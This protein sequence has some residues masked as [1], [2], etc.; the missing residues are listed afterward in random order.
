MTD[1][2]FIKGLNLLVAL[3]ESAE[4]RSLTRLAEQLGLTKSNTHRL[5]STLIDQGF[6]AQDGEKGLY[7]PTLRMWELGAAI[8]GRVD[9]LSVSREVL[10]RL[11]GETG[12][13][14]HLSTLAGHEVVY[15]AKID[16]HHAIR[17][18]TQVGGRAPA[19]CVATGK[20]MAAFRPEGEIEEIRARTPQATPRSLTGREA[21]LEEMS[22]IRETGIA[23][24]RGEW[25]AD[26][27]GAAAPVRDAQC[28]VIAAIGISGPFERLVGDGMERFADP[29]RLA[30]R[31]IS[32]MMGWIDDG[33]ACGHVHRD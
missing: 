31:D 19:L 20:A 28:R 6:A 1:K 7:R 22:Q 24:N 5:L 2:A 13:T 15:L 14:V 21:V 16:S 4:P 33:S 23:Y 8:V 17:A 32:R 10:E 12:E 26:V 3:A 27:A 11:A 25:R 29:V 9:V 30:A 18:Y